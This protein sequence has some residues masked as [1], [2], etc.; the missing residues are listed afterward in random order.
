MS[1]ARRLFVFNRLEI[2]YSYDTTNVF[3][4]AAADLAEVRL[5]FVKLLFQ[6][7]QELPLESVDVFNVAKDGAK[8]LLVE[9]V[10]PLAALFDITLRGKRNRIRAS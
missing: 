2:A 4:E 3:E 5:L 8:L 10:C 6:V 1:D 9:H 7:F